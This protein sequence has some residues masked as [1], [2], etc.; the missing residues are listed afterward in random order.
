MHPMLYEDLVQQYNRVQN[1]VVPRMMREI[2]V[3]KLNEE[4]LRM[5]I[6][7]VKE[8]VESKELEIERLEKKLHN[9]EQAIASQQVQIHSLTSKIATN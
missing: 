6:H 1:E 5:E 2:E 4:K 7:S 9:S 3:A 8:I